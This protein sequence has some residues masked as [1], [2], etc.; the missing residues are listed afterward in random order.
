MRRHIIYIFII[1]FITEIIKQYTI[2]FYT[3]GKQN[4]LMMNDDVL[5]YS[6]KVDAEEEQQLWVRHD[7]WPECAHT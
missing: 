3:K 5:L 6:S 4:A 1:N 7:T 2:T